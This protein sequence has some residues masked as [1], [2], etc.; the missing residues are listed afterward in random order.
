MKAKKSLFFGGGG[1][2]GSEADPL[3]VLRGP[4][5]PAAARTTSPFPGTEGRSSPP[6]PSPVFLRYS[7]P[8]KLTVCIKTR[9]EWLM[10]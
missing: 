10:V 7:L 1:V 5:P 3:Q 9:A 8:F 4:V 6:I 2:G